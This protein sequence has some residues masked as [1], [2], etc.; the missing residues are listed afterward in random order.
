[1]RMSHRKMQR[2]VILQGVVAVVAVLALILSLT[3]LRAQIHDIQSSRQAAGTDS[4]RLLRTLVLDSA[5]HTPA[6]QAHAH[7]FLDATPLRHCR[8]YG[9]EVRRSR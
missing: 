3:S 9:R 5:P 1:M 7:H 8:A 4:C 6:G 2:V